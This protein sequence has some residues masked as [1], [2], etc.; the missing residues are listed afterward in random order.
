MKAG[1]SVPTNIVIN[2]EADLRRAFSELGNSER[3]IWIRAS[4]IGGVE[5]VL[6]QQTILN[7]LAVG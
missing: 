7:L 5:K 2:D 1:L 3:K 4:S 6:Y